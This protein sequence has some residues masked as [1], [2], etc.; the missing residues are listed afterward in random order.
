M[1]VV[2]D[3]AG[4]ERAVVMGFSEG[5][6][7]QRGVRR[8][9]PGAPPDSLVLVGGFA[10]M[11]YDDDYEWGTAVTEVTESLQTG[12]WEKPGATTPVFSSCG[13][14]ASRTIQ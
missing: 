6:S 11:L 13:P 7:A 4:S 9:P 8:H 14:R 2:M 10:R 1:R 5:A 3:A 12:G